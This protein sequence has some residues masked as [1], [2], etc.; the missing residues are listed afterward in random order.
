MFGGLQSS[1]SVEGR[2]VGNLFSLLILVCLQLPHVDFLLRRPFSAF[3]HS[4]AP[5]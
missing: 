1:E 3:R 5:P 2:R 4:S